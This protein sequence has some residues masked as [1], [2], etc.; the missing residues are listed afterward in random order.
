MGKCLPSLR[1]I[2]TEGRI[3]L[4]ESF[5]VFCLHLQ[6]LHCGFPPNY[7]SITYSVQNI[8]KTEKHR[9]KITKFT[10]YYTTGDKQYCLFD[11][12]HF[13]LFCFNY[14]YAKPTSTHKNYKLFAFILQ[15][16]IYL[17]YIILYYITLHYIILYFNCIIF[18]FQEVFKTT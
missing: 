18:L 7:K 15:I 2:S 5:L 1:H 17:Y 10:Y 13:Y 6:H 3:V 14:C 12:C 8:W 16:Y 11:I 4:F 9:T